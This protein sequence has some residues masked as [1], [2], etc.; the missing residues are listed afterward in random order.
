MNVD[1]PMW[2]LE[3]GPNLMCKDCPV[4][5]FYKVERLFAVKEV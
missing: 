1:C 3:P 4:F 5:S 2:P